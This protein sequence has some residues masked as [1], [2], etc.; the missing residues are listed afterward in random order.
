M[1]EINSCLLR[2]VYT[3]PTE[4]NRKRTY[5]Y[6]HH[7]SKHLHF[8]KRTT[9]SQTYH[10]FSKCTTNSPN[11]F[12][13]TYLCFSQHI[14]FSMKIFLQIYLHFIKHLHSTKHIS[15][16]HIS[17]STNISP[18]LQTLL[19]TFQTF[20]VCTSRSLYSWGITNLTNIRIS[21]AKGVL[22][23]CLSRA[24][25][26]CIRLF[27]YSPFLISPFLS[28]IF[29]LF[30]CSVFIFSIFAFSMFA[31]S[32]LARFVFRH[33]HVQLFL[34]LPFP[35]LLLPISPFQILL[36]HQTQGHRWGKH[37]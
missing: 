13:P 2:A 31:F 19:Q 22:A 36:F 12:L 25:L 14:S 1:L 28:L 4:F 27:D 24:R 3:T 34:R 29:A 8:S 30:A 23:F 6:S 17:I 26:L 35:Y 37:T 18:F 5:C 15:S 16:E 33:F 9:I 11:I 32:I 10:H 21:M 20:K 7:F